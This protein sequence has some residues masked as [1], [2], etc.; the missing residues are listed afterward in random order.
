MAQQSP[1]VID[2]LAACGAFTCTSFLLLNGKSPQARKCLQDAL[3]LKHQSVASLKKL[4]DN[5]SPLYLEAALAVVAN[6]ILIGLM[7]H[8]CHSLYQANFSG[9]LQNQGFEGTS[10]TLEMHITGI[11]TMVKLLGGYESLV[12][13]S[14]SCGNAAAFSGN[15]TQKFP[16]SPIFEVKTER[17]FSELVAMN[18]DIHSTPLHFVSGLINTM[19]FASLDPRL[20][21]LIHS[22]KWIVLTYEGILHINNR[23]NSVKDDYLTLCEYRLLDFDE[24]PLTPFEDTI[25]LTIVLYS[26]VRLYTLPP[27]QCERFIITYLQPKIKE[28]SEQI[29]K[30]SPDLWFWVLWVAVL[31]S[32]GLGECHEFFVQHLLE[33]A[34]SRGIKTWPDAS[35]ILER[36]LFVD[37]GASEP[38]KAFWNSVQVSMHGKFS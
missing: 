1:I 37:R 4:L 3:Q 12:N 30:I 14:K 5:P 23:F 19:W 20:Q 8:D 31:G 27:Q 28:T 25:R 9:Y 35:N 15:M 21:N 22:Y 11:K 17:H 36:F 38:G 33:V 2:V 10:E 16:M 32:V 24:D 6:L 13:S 29:Q 34:F 18:H 7:N 26:V